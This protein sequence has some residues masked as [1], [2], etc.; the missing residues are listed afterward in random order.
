MEDERNSSTEETRT[1]SETDTRTA[2]VRERDATTNRRRVL[3][4]GGI[5][6]VA[7]LGI[8]L[9]TDESTD[10]QT[11]V[12]TLD[13]DVETYEATEIDETGA[14]LN[15]E[16]VVREGTLE[17]AAV[18]FEYEPVDQSTGREV[19]AGI[20]TEPG[21]F[22]KRVDDLEPGTEY[23]F[24]ARAETADEHLVGDTRTLETADEISVTLTRGGGNE[25]A[26]EDESLTYWSFIPHMRVSEPLDL[27]ADSVYHAEI[28][29]PATGEVVTSTIPAGGE[30]DEIT[31][32]SFRVYDG[33]GHELSNP[34]IFADEGAQIEVEVGGAT[35]MFS[36]GNVF[37]EYV[38]RVFEDDRLLDETKP[39]LVGI[40]YPG[41]YR[42]DGEE[43]RLQRHEEVGEEWT[44]TA[45]I[46]DQQANETIEE[47]DVVVDGDE[48]VVHLDQSVDE[49]ELWLH[50][51]L[52]E[53]EIPSLWISWVPPR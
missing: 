23:Q 11:Q 6:T 51:Y 24:R 46:R 27:A 20:V 29:K 13:W 21:P 25:R 43:F 48:F 38:Y 30:R 41:Y 31:R 52:P 16:L 5:G 53:S 44:I 9:Y 10:D 28:E 40:G 8:Y 49:Q 1:D 42:Y 32:L 12:D 37:D 26:R 22:S 3:V 4:G 36:T 2:P 18:S 14:T 45:Q 50:M 35:E 33:E 47:R 17:E 19:P 34:R 39:H 15:G 7:L